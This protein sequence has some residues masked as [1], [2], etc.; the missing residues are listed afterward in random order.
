MCYSDM[1]TVLHHASMR[2]STAN[3]HISYTYMH[4]QEAVPIDS[5]HDASRLS[6]ERFHHIVFGIQPDGSIVLYVGNDSVSRAL[7]VGG[8]LR[9]LQG[10][11][12]RRRTG[13][14]DRTVVKHAEHVLVAREHGTAGWPGDEKA[15]L[16]HQTG[17][18]QRYIVR[19]QKRE[20][21][22]CRTDSERAKPKSYISQAER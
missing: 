3:A 12:H 13:V 15:A 4:M 6:F 16:V 18:A 5:R 19:K 14:G 17:I 1:I 20:T 11:C 8:F 21:K 22:T 9:S 10:A 2:L 7:G